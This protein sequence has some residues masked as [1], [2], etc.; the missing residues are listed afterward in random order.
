MKLYPQEGFYLF[1]PTAQIFILAD[2]PGAAENIKRF[3]DVPAVNKQ[4][5]EMFFELT[6]ARTT[7]E[8]KLELLK[9]AIQK[10]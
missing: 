4:A 6:Q 10:L 2:H 7:A 8:A 1:G 5:L 9:A 3:P